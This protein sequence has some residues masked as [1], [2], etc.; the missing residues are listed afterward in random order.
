[1]NLFKGVADCYTL[2]KETEE[3]NMNKIPR[4]MKE[5]ANAQRK[6]LK[7]NELMQ[8]IYKTMAMEKIDRILRNVERGLITIDEGMK[9]LCNPLDGILE[10]EEK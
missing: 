4:Y 10:T 1:M 7:N 9:A 5:Y 8:E 6:S 3:T 2:L